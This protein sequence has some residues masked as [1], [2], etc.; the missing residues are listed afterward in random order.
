MKATIYLRLE[1]AL[2]NRLREIADCEKRSVTSLIVKIL[3]DYSQKYG[4]QNAGI[5]ATA[6]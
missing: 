5:T 3:S 2:K 6:N 4:V 1:E